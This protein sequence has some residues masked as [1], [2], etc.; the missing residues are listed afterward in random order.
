[1]KVVVD[2]QKLINPYS[3]LGQ[4]CF[5]LGKE[6]LNQN[7]ENEFLFLGKKSDAFNKEVNFFVPGLI[8][9]I[10]GFASKDI[11]LW[12]CTHQEP[13]YIPKNIPYIL[14]IHDLNFLY[15][16][17]SEWR[18]NIKIKKLQNLI[19]NAAAVVAVSE[20]TLKEVNNHFIIP[21]IS[22][23][24]IYNGVSLNTQTM[25]KQPDFACGQPFLFT[26]GII[27]PK[28]NFHVLIPFI[29][30][31]NYSLII[32]GDN[33]SGY[34]QEIIKQAETLGIAD[35]VILPGKVTE[36]EK[37]WLHRNCD[38]FVFPSMSEGFGLPVAEAMAMGKPVFLS[39][40][41]SLPEIGGEVAFYWRNF[42][43]K[44][45]AEIFISKM[46]LFHSDNSYQKKLQEQSIKFS[47]KDAGRQYLAL[48]SSLA[49][50]K[51]K[52]H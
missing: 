14:T 46:E 34:A 13:K 29:K 3:G 36:E 47:W 9:K 52:T 51:D 2:M 41:T 37:L 7:K 22:Q 40:K 27:S 44:S 50:K 24:V 10:T 23:Q 39:D 5:H 4:F 11:E 12:H 19:T 17:K 25:E 42:E 28:K 1:M 18:I 15:K 16:Y 6:L 8:N 49:G 45:M 31:L 43:P 35:K 21:D 38:A 20:F 33:K 48:Y 26:I 30:E 32:A